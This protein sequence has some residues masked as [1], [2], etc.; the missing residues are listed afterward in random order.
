MIDICQESFDLHYAVRHGQAFKVL[1]LVE[2]GIDARKADF[3]GGTLLMESAYR[4]HVDCARAL[5]AVS[6]CDAANEE[7]FTALLF[8][9]DRGHLDC[10]RLLMPVSDCNAATACGYT[11]LMLAARGGHVDCVRALVPSSNIVAV[12]HWGHSAAN[13]AETSG[14]DKLADLI[15]AYQLAEEERAELSALT[16]EP[17]SARR[18][19]RS[20]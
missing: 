8:A 6:D 2:S 7:G 16:G 14:H 5:T 15:V 9:A 11:A 20:L 10:I 1:R 12:D 4:G 17:R 13:L 19:A 18:K 3:T